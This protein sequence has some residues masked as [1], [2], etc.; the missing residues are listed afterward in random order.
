MPY[1]YVKILATKNKNDV[2]IRFGTNSNT[3]LQD[4]NTF[5]TIFTKTIVPK[6]LSL[7]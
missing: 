4:K 3:F 6:E 7:I 5:T 1:N 2:K